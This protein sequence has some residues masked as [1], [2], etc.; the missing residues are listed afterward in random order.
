MQCHYD[1]LN[2]EQDA[3]DTEIKRAY[4]KAALKWHPDKNLERLDEATEKFQL[5]QSAYAVL[6]DPQERTWYDDHRE[7]IL[8]GGTGT[9]DG[10]GN[11]IDLMG[12]FSTTCF[13]GHGDGPEGFFAV[14][15]DIFQR[16]FDTEAFTREGENVVAPPFGNLSSDYVSIVQPF[17]RYW[18][19]FSSL[20]TFAHLDKWDTREAP[21]RYVKR[22]MEKENKKL[23][24]AARKEYTATVRQLATFVQ[25]RDK[26]VIQHQRELAEERER[27]AQAAKEKQEKLKK[28]RAKDVQKML[29][30]VEDKVDWTERE[31]EFEALEETLDAEYGRASESDEEA[32]I[33]PFEDWFCVA[34]N[35][36]FKSDKQWQNHERSKKHLAMVSALRASMVEDDNAHAAVAAG[37]GGLAEATIDGDLEDFADNAAASSG[38]PI[39]DLD[40]IPLEDGIPLDSTNTEGT[41]DLGDTAS[42]NACNATA[43]SDDDDSDDDGDVLQRMLRGFGAVSVGAG[44]GSAAAA[45]DSSDSEGGFVHVD[46]GSSSDESS[47]DFVM[48][49]QNMEHG[50]STLT[51]TVPLMD[52]GESAGKVPLA[53]SRVNGDRNDESIGAETQRHKDASVLNN[54]QHESSTAQ[55][56]RQG[57]GNDHKKKRQLR[58]AI[59]EARKAGG[60]PASVRSVPVSG[61]SVRCQ[62]CAETFESRNQLFLHISATGHAVLKDTPAPKGPK[63]GK[64]KGKKKR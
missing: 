21:T 25:K 9:G 3:T 18:C 42:A 10:D 11:G 12:Y 43:S 40:G 64:K 54:V 36:G 51:E 22:Q 5:V 33:P 53:S 1:V 52:E 24:D 62:V 37:S 56:G 44:Q 39:S 38:A 17:Y 47:D 35:K 63:G 29:E 46:T 50:D 20:N 13:R 28:Q 15:T 30:S 23:R 31:R 34:C 27:S 6:S 8:R 45:A 55:S 60:A 59:E 14:Y 2:V 57:K 16:I 48:V 41:S 26:R 4:R 19:N 7:S 58:K 32:E 49:N 61:L